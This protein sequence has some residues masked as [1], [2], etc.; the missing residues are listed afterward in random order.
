MGSSNYVVIILSGR[1]M[2]K[3]KERDYMYLHGLFFSYNFILIPNGPLRCQKNKISLILNIEHKDQRF[4][5][6]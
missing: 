3:Q 6:H 5:G 4:S 1:K 2:G